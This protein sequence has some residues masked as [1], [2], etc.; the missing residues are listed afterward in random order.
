[1]TPKPACLLLLVLCVLAQGCA[2]SPALR[3]A[4]WGVTGLSYIATGK[5]LGDNAISALLEQDCVLLRG[6]AGN[7]VC[8]IHER[9]AEAEPEPAPAI[10]PVGTLPRTTLARAAKPGLEKRAAGRLLR[11]SLARVSKPA[12]A[13]LASP[14]LFVVAGSFRNLS[15][16]NR[17]RDQ[18]TKLYG[19]A[20]RATVVTA[21]VNGNLWH[22]V[23]LG[24]FGLTMS[25]LARIEPA[26]S[27]LANGWVLRLCSQSLLPPPCNQ[28]LARS[29]ATDSEV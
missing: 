12:S 26:A 23:I 7:A 21:E 24:P 25:E 6:L 22:R 16:A 2:V 8:R 28:L 5:S 18:K 14:Q 13:D 1:M 27:E 17:Q 11:T 10:E 20:T 3:I 9:L 29:M 15:N 19:A 4:N